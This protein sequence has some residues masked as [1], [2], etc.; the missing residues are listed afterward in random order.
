MRQRPD[1]LRHARRVIHA[2]QQI[3]ALFDH[4]IGQ[5]VEEPPRGQAH[6]FGTAC[7]LQARRIIHRQLD[8]DRQ[9]RPRV[10]RQVLDQRL[11]E[12]G[13]VAGDRHRQVQHDRIARFRRGHKAVAARDRI[14]IQRDPRLPAKNAVIVRSGERQRHLPLG[15]R[16]RQRLHLVRPLLRGIAEGHARR[17][18]GAHH[19]V[20]IAPT[21]ARDGQC[22]R[23]GDGE[24]L[25]GGG[26][27]G[28]LGP[29]SLGQILRHAQRAQ[30]AIK[31]QGDAAALRH[32]DA[33]AGLIG[34]IERRLP[35]IGGRFDPAF[36]CRAARHRLRP[37]GRHLGDRA[38]A[39]ERSEKNRHRQ[40]Q[41]RH[42]ARGKGIAGGHVQIGGHGAR[43]R[44]TR[45]HAGLMRLPDR[46][47]CGIGS[48]DG[49]TVQHGRDRTSG[50]AGIQPRER[51]GP[52][53]PAKPHYA[54]RSCH[55]RA[56]TG[57][58]HPGPDNLDGQTVM[59]AQHQRRQRQ[60]H[61]RPERPEGLPDPFRQKARAGQEQRPAQ[62]CQKGFGGFNH[63]CIPRHCAG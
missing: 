58:E 46:H 49:L 35:G 2:P 6:L 36:P 7:A 44:R 14:Q 3:A 41:Q 51:L 17:R 31:A 54:S 10:L 5:W 61:H 8:P 1:H 15:P 13:P 47:G 29:H 55:D 16:L 23:T 20:P 22:S 63:G 52:R 9:V 37:A 43:R 19:H 56:Q 25:R 53:G 4:R 33:L 21:G 26:G 50:Q 59:Q 12:L 42:I 30:L 57:R 34:Q 40:R 45:R 11:G 48:A 28:G 39:Q 18:I 32:L 38:H 60:H 27:I 24:I 62:A